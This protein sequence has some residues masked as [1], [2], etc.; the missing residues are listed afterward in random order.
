MKPYNGNILG[1]RNFKPANL[2]AKFFRLVLDSSS[3]QA[4]YKQNLDASQNFPN[5]NTDLWS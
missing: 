2:T 4:I 1:L 5:P 3:F